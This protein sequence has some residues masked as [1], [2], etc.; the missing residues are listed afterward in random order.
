MVLVNLIKNSVTKGRKNNFLGTFLGHSS[1]K[2]CKLENNAKKTVRVCCLRL[3]RI[4]VRVIVSFICKLVCFACTKYMWGKYTRCAHI[5][6]GA[7]F[8]WQKHILIMLPQSCKS[9]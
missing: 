1:K 4:L 8:Y 6:Y 2:Y 5:G 7:V 9:E 3:K